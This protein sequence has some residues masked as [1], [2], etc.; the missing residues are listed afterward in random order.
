MTVYDLIDSGGKFTV[1]N[2]TL[3]LKAVPNKS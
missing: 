2:A 1:T 3:Y